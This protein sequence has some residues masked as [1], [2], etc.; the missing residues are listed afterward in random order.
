[1]FEM[2]LILI[3]YCY[4]FWFGFLKYEFSVFCNM[5]FI[6]YLYFFLFFGVNYGGEF[7]LNYIYGCYIL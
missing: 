4:I 7:Y 6:D 5:Y 3:K 1:M 2:L